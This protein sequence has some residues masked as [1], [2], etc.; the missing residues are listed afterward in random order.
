M[1]DH[2]AHEGHD[3]D[4]DHGH[5][6]GH[7]HAHS[8]PDSNLAFAIGIA[9]NVGFVLIEAGYG[10]AA[11]SLALLSDAAHNL[12]DVFG[13]L[14]AWGAIRLGKS[15][16]TKHRTYGLRRSSILAALGNAI[17]LLIVVGG[18]VWEAF[19]RIAHPEMVASGVVIWVAAAGVV[20]NSITA[21]LFMAG[22]KNDININGA[23]LHMA[24][25]A[26]ISL[27]VV[28]VGFGINATGW[29]WLD[30]AVSILIG[31]VIVW[32]TWSLLRESFNLATDAVPAGIDPHAVES[33]LTGLPGVEAIH[34]LHIWGMSTTEAALT[35]HLVMPEPPANDKF[36]HGL[37][38][39]LRGRF[40]IGHAT[41]QIEHGDPDLFCH[42][43]PAD[44]V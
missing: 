36:L 12:S 31:I 1:A 9:L 3:Q 35:V 27:G 2:H 15:L 7:G 44:V 42:Q 28:L 39:E 26:G 24:G 33:Y 8:P 14:M 41:I 16:P 19:G 43:A 32:S 30:P 4:H 34:D 38:G 17:V 18:I 11:N 21:L 20:I 25:D 10:L 13:L 40:G 29:L 23:F 37:C 5:G 22:R 6:H